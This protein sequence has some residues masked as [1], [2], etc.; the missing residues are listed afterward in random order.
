[1]WIVAMLLLLFSHTWLTDAA[2]LSTLPPAHR[3]DEQ[4]RQTLKRYRQIMDQGG[5]PILPEGP[6]LHPGDTGLS[7]LLL[8]RRLQATDDLLASEPTQDRT[9][10]DDA[11]ANALRRFQR[12]HGL[13]ADGMVGPDT[14]VALQVPIEDRIHQL[15]LNLDRWRELPQDLG[16]RYIWVNIPAFTL[17]V[18]EYDQPVMTM[19]VVVGKPSW[20]TPVLRAQVT[21]LV[22]NPFWEIPPRI[23]QQEIIPHLRRDP[24]YL[25]THHM[26]LLQAQGGKVT[27]IDPATVDW[28]KP[29]LHDMPYRLRQRPG[30]TNPLGRVKFI[31]PNPFHITLHDTPSRDLFAKT[32]RAQSHGCIRLEKPIAL[33]EYLLR[34]DHKW[35]REAILDII[36]QGTPQ[37]VTIPTPIPV[38]LIYHTAWVDRDGEAHF[39]PDIYQLDTPLHVTPDEGQPAACR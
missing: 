22:F 3:H 2:D 19:R 17:K 9:L 27:E 25:T 5:W 32:M 18:V 12:R 16:P 8:R 39:R 30:P 31:I 33:A 14:R 28:S 13:E 11:L 10:F 6:T 29:L 4:L 20:P 21:A 36:H 7:I 38:Y 37:Q 35:T 34:E 1:M 23:I 15:I 24:T 26:I